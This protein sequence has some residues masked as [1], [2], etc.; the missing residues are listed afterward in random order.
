MLQVG[1]GMFL[2]LNRRELP[3]VAWLP[4]YCV[5]KDDR[6]HGAPAS[7]LH[8]PE[9]E[10]AQ[11]LYPWRACNC[12]VAWAVPDA[13]W[14]VWAVPGAPRHGS[15]CWNKKLNW[16]IPF[17]DNAFKHGHLDIKHFGSLDEALRGYY[18]GASRRQLF[19]PARL[20]LW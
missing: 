12:Y 5:S 2:I 6:G 13:E 14:L 20:H 15:V 3:A 8:V 11:L 7:S 1:G 16:A 9:D 18:D 19:G 10:P 17:G 4:L